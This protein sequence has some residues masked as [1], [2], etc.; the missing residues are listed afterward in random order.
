M[1]HVYVVQNQHR[2]DDRTGNLEPKFDMSSAAK[3]GELV[4]L[5]SPTAR[6]FSPIPLIKQLRDKLSKFNS[7]DHLLLIGNPCL[8]GFAVGIAAEMNNGRVNV[9][10]WDGRRREYI[11]VMANLRPQ[12]LTRNYHGCRAAEYDGENLVRCS[13]GIDHDGHHK[14]VI[15]K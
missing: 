9:L 5:L 15:V 7:E 3:Y 11:S 14:M 2:M 10:Q 1:S 12:T 6:P 4:Y 13:L 8:I